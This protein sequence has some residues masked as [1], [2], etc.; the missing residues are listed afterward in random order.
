MIFFLDS[1]E[2][3]ETYFR[4]MEIVDLSGWLIP[5]NRVNEFEKVWQAFEDDDK[6]VEYYCFAEP[7]IEGEKVKVEFKYY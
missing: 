7:R 3:C 5:Q 2:G 6:W 4:D 1:A